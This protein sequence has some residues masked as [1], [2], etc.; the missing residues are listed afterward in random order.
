MLI[1]LN[2]FK[3]RFSKVEAEPLDNSAELQT[4]ENQYPAKKETISAGHG[5]ST[6]VYAQSYDGSKNLGET[7]PIIDWIPNYYRLSLRSWQSYTENE[8]TQTI[9]NKY[10]IWIID[11][12]LKLQAN[13]SKKVLKIKKIN[14]DSENF[15]EACES[16]FLIWSKSVNST[17]NKI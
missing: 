5:Y 10:C 1:E 3:W 13:P 15:N 2:P 6:M 4:S 17:F 7:G 8:I 14:I 16:M 11:K 9:L 12:G